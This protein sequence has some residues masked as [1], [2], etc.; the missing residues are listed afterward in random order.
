M[1]TK[2]LEENELNAG[3]SV[4]FNSHP[5]QSDRQVKIPMETLRRHLICT[6]QTGSGKTSVLEEMI[7]SLIIQK[8]K[9]D[10]IGFTLFD[11]KFGACIGVQNAIDKLA[12]DGIIEDKEQFMKK[13]RYINLKDENCNFGIN[14]ID[15]NLDNTELI[16]YFRQLFKTT[17]VQLERY[18][19]HAVNLLLLDDKNHTISDILKLFTDDDYRIDMYTS[20][21]QK[22]SSKVEPLIE[23][24]KTEKFKEERL[25]PIKNR[26]APFTSDEQ[27]AKIF[28]SK[29]SLEIE[30]WIEQ[31]YI[32]MFN[33]DGFSSLEIEMII[34]F[35][36]LKYYLYALKRKEGSHSHFLIVDEA[37]DVQLDIFEKM[38]AKTRSRGLHL[39]LFTQFLEQMNESLR[40]A[41]VGNM[42]TKII[43]QQGV[44]ASKRASKIVKI[45]ASRIEELQK[46]KAYVVTEDEK[47]EI[48]KILI[49]ASPP[50]RYSKEGKVLPYSHEKPEIDKEFKKAISMRNDELERELNKNM[51][52][53]YGPKNKQANKKEK[54]NNKNIFSNQEN[55]FL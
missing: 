33:L 47:N 13:V 4:G 12:A 24:L 40:K 23:T 50:F 28:N 16:N 37:H 22:K 41:I 26:I 15:K 19:S 9:G 48:K 53:N 20:V 25:D 31:G 5:S 27:K 30:K 45:D 38:I 34:G 14:L 42:S 44:D 6:G 2:I 29:D 39:F 1:Y 21:I 32:I 8:A 49:N 17:G 52:M 46:M 55:V 36:S 35:I 11:P 43:L 18:I 54:S 7:K 51:F 10:N 3:I